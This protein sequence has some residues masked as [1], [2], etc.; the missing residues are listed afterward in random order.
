[1]S[2]GAARVV[3]WVDVYTLHLADVLGLHC[4][5]RKEVVAVDEYIVGESRA[6][7]AIT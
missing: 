3:W 1:M 7:A 6:S 2:E 4:F 5:E